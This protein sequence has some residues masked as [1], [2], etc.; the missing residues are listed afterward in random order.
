M[1]KKNEWADR[2]LTML[3]FLFAFVGTWCLL[4]FGVPSL[5][6]KMDSVDGDFFGASLRHMAFLK[7]LGSTGLGVV[8]AM[9][10]RV[11][12]KK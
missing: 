1:N 9:I 6:I 10:P 12:N 4:S 5:R 2:V 3:L 7:F 8:V 11:F